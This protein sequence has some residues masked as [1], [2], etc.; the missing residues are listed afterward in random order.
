MDEWQISDTHLLTPGLRYQRQ[1]NW[2]R[3][4]LG[5]EQERRYA[6]FSPSLHY[7]WQA[8][9]NW[10]LR[11]SLGENEKPPGL[12]EMSHMVRESNGN[13]SP[14]NPDKG[15]N[16][17]LKAERTRALEVGV[18][19]FLPQRQ[20]NLGLNLFRR[21]V[22]NHVEKIT[23]LENGRWVERPWNVGD[24]VLTGAL[25]DWKMRLTALG[26]PNLNL[27]GNY[28][29]AKIRIAQ[30]SPHP[31]KEGPR[32]AWNLGFDYDLPAHRLTLGGNLSG[33]GNLVKAQ[34]GR[35]YQEYKGSQQ[36]DLY[37]LKRI[38]RQLAVR[39]S[40]SNVTHADRDNEV[41]SH[42]PDGSLTSRE[43]SHETHPPVYKVSLEARW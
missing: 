23:A 21:W 10:N 40:A 37:L 30:E 38:N 43:R 12:R 24:A 19:H 41:H 3:D 32:R 15:G 36:L 9:S 6:S 1:Y 26:L 28:S 11:A 34:K 25:L 39:L 35:L 18:E 17:N 4:G 20:G 29:H 27:R 2:S 31:Q 14:G 7:L 5:T 22:S 16:P 13:N 8:S 42:A 33:R